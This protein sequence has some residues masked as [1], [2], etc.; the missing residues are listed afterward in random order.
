[1][2][3][4]DHDGWSL[5]NGDG[6]WSDV[7]AR[8]YLAAWVQE[9]RA[10]TAEFGFALDALAGCEELHLA[11][12]LHTLSNTYRLAAVSRETVRDRARDLERAATAVR[13]LF[14]SQLG[15][16]LGLRTLRLEGELRDLARAANSLAPDVH[17]RRP[18]QRDLVR[19]ALVNYVYRTTAQF[20]DDHVAALISVAESENPIV[21]SLTG[22]EH[23]DQSTYTTE[24][25]VQWR[26][27]ESCQD[28]LNG[29]SQAIRDLEAAMERDLAGG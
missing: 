17:A 4:G 20:H 3:N 27:R 6:E 28:F 21:E 11:W 25:H 12:L 18:M 8:A 9:R 10:E 14:F 16:V 13:R 5:P 15:P 23:N 29:P 2:G 19:A 22:L 24:A 1:M 7:G 26:Q